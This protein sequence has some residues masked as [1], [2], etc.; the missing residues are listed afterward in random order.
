MA[1]DY[2]FRALEEHELVYLNRALKSDVRMPA[3]NLEETCLYVTGYSSGS[4]A[5][6]VHVEVLKD[7][8]TSVEI[9]ERTQFYLP[10]NP[11]QLVVSSKLVRGKAVVHQFYTELPIERR[12]LVYV[13]S[14]SDPSEFDEVASDAASQLRRQYKKSY[15]E[16]MAKTPLKD[17]IFTHLIR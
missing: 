4:R 14:A 1:D 8:T 5:V 16:E 12:G 6:N 2:N 13:P 17:I 7:G 11:A 10:H 15:G 3:K 9:M